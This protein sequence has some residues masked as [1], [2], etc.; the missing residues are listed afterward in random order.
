MPLNTAL[1]RFLLI[2]CCSAAIGLCNMLFKGNRLQAGLSLMEA[3]SVVCSGDSRALQNL[4][5]MYRQVHSVAAECVGWPCNLAL[6]LQVGMISESIR[7][8]ARGF[9]LNSRDPLAVV[10]LLEVITRDRTAAIA[11]GINASAV[12]LSA[13]E[14]S[15]NGDIRAT[16]ALAELYNSVGQYAYARDSLA[17]ALAA[18]K[19]NERIGEKKSNADPNWSA[20]CLLMNLAHA[21]M[22]FVCS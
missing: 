15:E 21:G 6:A 16:K 22:R 18:S 20:K 2:L 7:T 19:N 5:M 10:S 14:L 8:I 3:S 13:Q 11:E 12:T 9:Q 1:V 4:G 17:R